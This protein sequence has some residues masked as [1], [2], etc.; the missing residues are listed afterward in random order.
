MPDR[1]KKDEWLEPLMA[2]E[3]FMRADERLGIIGVLSLI[4]LLSSLVLMVAAANIG[5]LV[6]SRA[7]G[8]AREI[9]GIEFDPVDARWSSEEF[10][11][12]CDQFLRWMGRLHQSHRACSTPA[13]LAAVPV[14]DDEVNLPTQNCRVA[15]KPLQRGPL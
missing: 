6:L 10:G 8:R 5:N 9:C 7:T 14:E 12:L 1:V 15:A 11:D 4:G 2:T 13:P 3:N